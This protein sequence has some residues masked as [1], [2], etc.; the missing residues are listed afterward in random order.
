M[1][2]L[3]CNA[4]NAIEYD[5]LSITAFRR[6][7]FCFS[8][9]GRL[10]D[11]GFGLMF[12]LRMMILQQRVSNSK[13]VLKVRKVGTGQHTLTKNC[14][15]SML[16]NVSDRM[17]STFKNRQNFGETREFENTVKKQT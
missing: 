7:G 3:R 17:T 13:Y 16:K 8:G 6:G 10:E 12:V 9:R 4:C 2:F 15:R 1:R 11:F 5:C 14:R